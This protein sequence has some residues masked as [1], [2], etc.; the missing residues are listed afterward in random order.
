MTSTK[1]TDVGNSTEIRTNLIVR[2]AAVFYAHNIPNLA[3]LN[4]L[5]ARKM[6]ANPQ[7]RDYAHRLNQDESIDSICLYC[8]ATVITTFSE[9]TREQAEAA[10]MCLPKQEA[11]ASPSLPDQTDFGEPSSTD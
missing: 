10:H 2:R 1:T 11:K 4:F 5:R 8:F 7:Q 3:S 6:H 9:W